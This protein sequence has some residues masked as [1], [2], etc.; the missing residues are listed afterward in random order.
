MLER[1]RRAKLAG[2]TVFHAVEG[3]GASGRVHRA[4]AF[5]DDEPVSLAIV[6]TPERVAEFVEKNQDLLADLLVAVHEVEL[7][8]F[9]NGSR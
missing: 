1:A 8:R 9:P 6:D 2:A 4:R 7:L 5:Q 3:Y